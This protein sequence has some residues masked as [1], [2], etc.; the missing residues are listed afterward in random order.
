LLTT[1]KNLSFFPRDQLDA[2]KA[3]TRHYV[4]FGHDTL[5]DREGQR[6]AVEVVFDVL[7][8]AA[9]KEPKKRSKGFG[10]EYLFPRE[11]RTRLNDPDLDPSDR[12]RVIVDYVA[13]CQSRS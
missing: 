3:L 11:Y 8:D 13:E 6:R 1:V 2:L 10:G 5:S 7:R 9:R 12:V 4:I